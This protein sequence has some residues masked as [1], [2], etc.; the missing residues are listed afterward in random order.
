MRELL[1]ES[2]LRIATLPWEYNLMNYQQL[3]TVC[4]KES[5]PRIL[6]HPHFHTGQSKNRAAVSSISELLRPALMR[7][8]QQS[9]EWDREIRNTAQIRV[10][11]SD[12]IRECR[13]WLYRRLPRRL[14][15]PWRT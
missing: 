14:R 3:R 7:K 1:W 6:H 15:K 4:K 8:L 12:I 13:R 10:S 2:D 5:A 9:L 11:A